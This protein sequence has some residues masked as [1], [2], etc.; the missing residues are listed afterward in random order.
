M[1]AKNLIIR[2]ESLTIRCINII[3]RDCYFV[4]RDL[5]NFHESDIQDFKIPPK[6]IRWFSG[7]KAKVTKK[8]CLCYVFELNTFVISSKLKQ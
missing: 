1:C 5:L 3:S 7:K 2:Q 8:I 4:F 6:I